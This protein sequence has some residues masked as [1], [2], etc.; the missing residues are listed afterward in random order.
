MSFFDGPSGRIPY[1]F[2]PARRPLAGLIFLHGAADSH[3]YHRLAMTL[4]ERQVSVLATNGV[5]EIQRDAPPHLS[6]LDVPARAVEMLAER[7]ARRLSGIPLVLGGHSLGG[8]AAALAVARNAGPYA[9]LVLSGTPFTR[10]TRLRGGPVSMDLSYLPMAFGGAAP[11]PVVESRALE[12]AWC[13]LAERFERVR[14]PV[15]FVHGGKDSLVPITDNR[16]WAYRLPVAQLAWFPRAGHDVFNTPG[17]PRA[18][19]TVA[20]FVLSVAL[21]QA[22]A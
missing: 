14:I 15:L 9:G 2:W 11:V 16:S 22:V 6:S 4:N 18:A 13:E 17:P 10:P 5:G 19:T 7:A 1:H 3:R 12:M 21:S 8:T 20:D